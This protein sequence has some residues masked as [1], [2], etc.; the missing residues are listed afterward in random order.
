MF[1]YAKI[2]YAPKVCS[3][4]FRS[5]ISPFGL[6]HVTFSFTLGQE[7]VCVGIKGGIRDVDTVIT[8]YR[9]HG[10][11]HM[12]GVS[13]QGVLSELT[14]KVSGCVRGKVGN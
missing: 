8:S 12:M 13:V 6:T 1:R 9:A 3:A 5:P 14:G 11:A 7:A 4:V 2:K 10:F